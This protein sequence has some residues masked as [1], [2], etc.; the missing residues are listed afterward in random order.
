MS[1]QE[2]VDRAIEEKKIVI[3]S[4]SWCPYCAKTKAL[5]AQEFPEEEPHVLELDKRDDGDAI[6]DYLAEKTNQRS[7]P[8]VFVKGQHVGG[9]DKTQLAFKEGKLVTMV[10]L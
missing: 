5:F 2:I 9:N 1:V 10:N 8:N 3:F 6:Q 7:V 4:K